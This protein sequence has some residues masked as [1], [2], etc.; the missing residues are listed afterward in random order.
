MLDNKYS[1]TKKLKIG[2]FG[3]VYCARGI[4]QDT[5]KYAVKFTHKPN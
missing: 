3:S 2:G 1:I 5:N 4:G